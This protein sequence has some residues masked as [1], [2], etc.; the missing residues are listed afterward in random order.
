[1]WV[2]SF[3]LPRI[4]LFYN[5]LV[6]VYK[7]GWEEGVMFYYGYSFI[8]FSRDQL[9]SKFVTPTLPSCAMLTRGGLGEN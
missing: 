5:K 1:M 8:H 4:N 3:N 2:V 9:S 7:F 6:G